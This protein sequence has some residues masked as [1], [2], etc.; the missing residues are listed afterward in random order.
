MQNLAIPAGMY[1]HKAVANHLWNTTCNVV[2]ELEYKR[3]HDVYDGAPCEWSAERGATHT[4]WCGE[5]PGRGSR[6]VIMKK[7][8][9]MVGIDEADDQIVWEKW[10]IKA[11]FLK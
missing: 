8:V 4:L 7:T 6:P 10:N 2:K 9:M 11:I 1:D 5:G 3:L